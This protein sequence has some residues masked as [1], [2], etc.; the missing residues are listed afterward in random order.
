M[1]QIGDTATGAVSHLEEIRNSQRENVAK[2]EDERRKELRKEEREAKKQR[3]EKSDGGETRSRNENERT[4]EEGSRE[5]K[6]VNDPGKRAGGD[7][8]G[9]QGVYSDGK[10]GTNT[11][12]L[13][14][15]A[16]VQCTYESPEPAASFE[17]NA[18][19]S[20]ILF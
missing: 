15:N 13:G 5:E 14:Y 11:R 12:A 1:L 3:R 6:P 10:Q 8:L 9:T 4:D 2:G 19:S 16:A 18:G 17:G 20:R 7:G